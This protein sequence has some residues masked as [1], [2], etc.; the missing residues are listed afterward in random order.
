M[1]RHSN[2]DIHLVRSNGNQIY[3]VVNRCRWN[4]FLFLF[5]LFYS[6]LI[7]NLICKETNWLK[8]A[9]KKSTLIKSEI[10]NNPNISFS[11]LNFKRLYFCLIKCF[12]LW[13]DSEKK[14]RSII[15]AT[16]VFPHLLQR[17]FVDSIVNSNLIVQRITSIDD[18][19]R[20]CSPPK[21]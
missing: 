19:E 8:K 15:M 9:T 20:S 14:L 7:L 13:A 17:R 18:P 10:E 21:Y 1:K 3:I 12:K 11:N 4:I 5:L 16:R 2:N 6:N